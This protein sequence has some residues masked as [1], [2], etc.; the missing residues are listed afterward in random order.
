[1]N[2][3]IKTT[4]FALALILPTTA[5]AFKVDGVSYGIINENEVSVANGNYCYGDIVIPE[6][7][8]YNGVTYTV[9][10]IA[11]SA[12]Y[13]N[14]D[15]T[16]IELPNTV[17]SIDE[18]AFF[19][20]HLISNFVIPNSVLTIGTK[21]FSN[22]DGITNLTIGNSVTTI[23]YQAFEYC[24]GLTS[25]EIPNSV[26]SL[27]DCAFYGCRSL[28]NVSIGNSITSIGYLTFAW[29]K[30]LKS[31]VIPNSVT[32]IAKQAFENCYALASIEIPETVNSIGES[33]FTNCYELAHITIDSRNDIYD[34]RN[35]CNAIIETA[36]NTLI[37]GSQN[38]IIPNTVTSIAKSAFASNHR[39]TNIAIPYSVSSIGKYA[40]SN[41]IALDSISVEDG[42][43]VYDSRN[44]CNA[45]IETS[46]NTLI[47]GCNKTCIPNSV[48]SIGDYAFYF[49]TNLKE[50]EIP[51]SVSAIGTNAFYYT[52][53]KYLTIGKSISH[54]DTYA[55]G[56]CD[57]LRMIKCL[58][59]NPPT[60]NN[61]TF[62]YS[63]SIYEKATLEVPP[64]AVSAY[65]NHEVWSKFQNIRAIETIAGDLDGNGELSISDVTNLIDLLLEGD[66]SVNVADVNGDGAITI[67]DV[68]LLID[69]LLGSGG[70]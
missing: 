31:I 33:A 34:S 35:D 58:A 60:I 50:I 65:Q 46:T 37:L 28:E 55:F 7:V 8:T 36:T 6:T 70:N 14:Y 13:R 56:D 68:T 42:N 38:T 2:N 27:G 1:M 41:C 49:Y 69:Q 20:C 62:N 4:L 39:L 9:T 59:I 67:R 18:Y 54:I 29:C 64:I 32:S 16:G 61:I 25:I 26:T 52:G 66:L 40:F 47:A 48:T 11:Q 12:F 15:L 10:S 23:D 22:C 30:S 5:T 53:I 57:S 21:A 3:F 45:I 51:N 63:D 44:N 17:T 43:P 24:Y 19:G